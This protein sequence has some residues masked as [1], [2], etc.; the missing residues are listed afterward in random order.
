MQQVAA[1]SAWIPS[2]VHL[3]SM[4]VSDGMQN[5]ALA[6]ASYT[7]LHAPALA[8]SQHD[9]QSALQS[10]APVLLEPGSTVVIVVVPLVVAPELLAPPELPV[11]SPDVAPV[12]MPGPPLVGVTPLLPPPLPVPLSLPP[13]L[14]VVTLV[15]GVAALAP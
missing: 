15:P 4:Q 9:A 12:L 6:Q 11:S 8:Q 14:T 13:A 1:Q 2:G 10:G 3:L 7:S 5:P